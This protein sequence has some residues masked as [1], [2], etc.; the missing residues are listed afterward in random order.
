MRIRSNMYVEQKRLAVLDQA[1]G[2]LQI[3]LA[4]ADGLDLGATEGHAGLKPVQQ[5]VVMAGGSVLR[6]VPLARGDRGAGPNRLLRP[7]TVRLYDNV[8]GLASHPGKTS[9]FHRSI[10]KANPHIADGLC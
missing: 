4:L 8:A 5:K 3:G 10:G 6:S 1:I 2:V 7:G 9:N